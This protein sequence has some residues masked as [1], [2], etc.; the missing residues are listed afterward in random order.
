MSTFRFDL[1]RATDLAMLR[2]WLLRPHVA[3]WWSPARS[4]DE[5]HEHY[6]RPQAEPGATLPYIASLDDEPIGFIQSYVAMGSGDGWWDDVTDPGVRGIDQFLAN[7]EQLGRG[8]GRALIA[9]FVDALFS[10]ASVTMIQAD[11]SPENMRAVRCYAGAGF[12]RTREIITP[13]GPAVL[14]HRPRP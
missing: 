10:D 2:S 5:L 14:M 11:P 13:D 7:G 3:E 4:I 8:I 9:S 6:V 1:V 12:Q